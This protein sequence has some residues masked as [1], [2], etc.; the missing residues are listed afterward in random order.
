MYSACVSDST[1]PTGYP[2]GLDDTSKLGFPLSD[3]VRTFTWYGGSSTGRTVYY[4]C[5]G[6]SDLLDDCI[7][8]SKDKAHLLTMGRLMQPC[9]SQELNA[10][11][12]A[13]IQ[14]SVS[15]AEEAQI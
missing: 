9:H 2:M 1:M 4:L 8:T 13:T 7:P 5:R 11:Q 12:S 10:Q 15:S 6:Q 14:A 3:F